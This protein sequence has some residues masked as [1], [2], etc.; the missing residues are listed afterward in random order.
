MFT[1]DS[2]SGLIAR[3]LNTNPLLHLTE[4]RKI[5]NQPKRNRNSHYIPHYGLQAAARNLRH[6][7]AG[8]HGL[9]IDKDGHVVFA[10]RG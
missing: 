4:A 2:I 1:Y 7:K 8:T 6:A 9:R 10:S 5:A 3:I